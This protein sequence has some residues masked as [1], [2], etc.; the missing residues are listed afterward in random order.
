MDG[1]DDPDHL[2]FKSGD[3]GSQA[4]VFCVC[5]PGLGFWEWVQIIVSL[6]PTGL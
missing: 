1:L 2:V 3:V 5:F 6:M 4:K